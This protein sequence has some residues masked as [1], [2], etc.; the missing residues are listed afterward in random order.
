M[1]ENRIHTI[2]QLRVKRK[3]FFIITISAHHSSTTTEKEGKQSIYEERV[4]GFNSDDH[5]NVILI[6]MSATAW[7]LMT[8]SSRFCKK[9]YGYNQTSQKWEIVDEQTKARRLTNVCPL[10]DIPWSLATNQEYK[11]GREV[12]LMVINFMFLVNH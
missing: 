2:G 3:L 4:N 9:L 8:E 12:R 11:K 6:F 10:F 5:P 7:N 1:S